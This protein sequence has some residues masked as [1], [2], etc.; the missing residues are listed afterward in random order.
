MKHYILAAVAITSLCLS[1][2]LF[3]SETKANV[4]QA[5]VTDN[6]ENFYFGLSD[7]INNG[8]YETAIKMVEEHFSSDFM[9]YD[10]GA[11]VYGKDCLLY[12][13]DAADE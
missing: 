5:S 3:A 6:V 12:T 13:S 1:P 4:E 9:H 2:I 10:D 8:E 11:P 7:K